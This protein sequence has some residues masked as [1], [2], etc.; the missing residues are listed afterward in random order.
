[1]EASKETG[2]QNKTNLLHYRF[3]DPRVED[4]LIYEDVL[5]L[6]IATTFFEMILDS[7]RGFLY[8]VI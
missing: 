6:L 1:M 7:S 8:N 5:A 4:K 3:G 2:K